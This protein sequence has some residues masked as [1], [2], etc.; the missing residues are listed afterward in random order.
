MSTFQPFT[1]C[2]RNF[3][4]FKIDEVWHIPTDSLQAYVK[5]RAD[6]AQKILKHSP[7]SLHGGWKAWPF[8]QFL[9]TDFSKLPE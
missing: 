5:E 9:E 6:R 1:N 8:G 3:G 7:V 2:A 4:A